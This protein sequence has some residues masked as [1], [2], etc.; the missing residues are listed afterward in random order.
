MTETDNFPIRHEGP[1]HSGKVRSVYWLTKDDSARIIRDECYED[2]GVYRDTQLGLM[3]ISDR[4]SAFNV[5]W[6]GEN[7]L[8]GVP[9]KGANLNTLSDTFF[10]WFDEIDPQY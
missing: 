3:I 8:G 5:Q 7:G 9:N 1:V 10:G 6:K 2:A 4:I